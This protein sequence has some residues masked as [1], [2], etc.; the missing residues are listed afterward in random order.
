M[1]LRAS[2]ILFSLRL[3]ITLHFY[4]MRKDYY[5][6]PYMLLLRY[7]DYADTSRHYITLII[8]ITPRRRLRLLIFAI[9]D[10]DID[11]PQL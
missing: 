6:M 9:T 4:L 8:A 3:F 7:A 5:A 10:A 2:L 1:L 11:T